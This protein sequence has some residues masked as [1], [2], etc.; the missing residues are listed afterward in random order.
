M[1]FRSQVTNHLFQ[2]E[3]SNF[4]F[5]LF[6]LNIQRGRDHGLA[7]YYQWRELCQVPPVND[8]LE[9]EKVIKPSS[10]VVLKQLYQ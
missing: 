1:Y 6:A 7:P 5:D 9:M 10:F 3:K 2:P 4:G 8:W